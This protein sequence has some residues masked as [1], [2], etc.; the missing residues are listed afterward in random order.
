M[1]RLCLW[2]FLASAGR[3]RAARAAV[4]RCDLGV[5]TRAPQLRPPSGLQ[6]Q[7]LGVE[8]LSGGAANGMRMMASDAVQPVPYVAARTVAP[9]PRLTP[10]SKPAADLGPLRI[11][12]RVG[13]GLVLVA[14]RRPALRRSLPRNISRPW[15]LRS[16][17]ARSGPTTVSTWCSAAAVSCFTR[18]STGRLARP[19]AGALVCQWAEPMDRRRRRCQA[20]LGGRPD[21]ASGGGAHHLY[22]GYRYHPILHFS[23]FH[24][25]ST[26]AP[27]GARRSSRRA[28]ARW[29]PRAGP[30]AMAARFAL[31][32]PA[33]C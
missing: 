29:S 26:S 24:A 10:V 20:E 21:D 18:A 1:P 28:T 19:P 2:R 22:F 12:G 31:L 13:D 25:G 15:Q 17:S 33:G 8:P 7:A 32:M 11:C 3:A 4:Q 30:G 27:A 9:Q 5:L 23:R 14:A 6:W 16:T